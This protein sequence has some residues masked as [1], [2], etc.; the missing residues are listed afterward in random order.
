[1]HLGI[2]RPNSQPSEAYKN[3][4]KHYPSE[5]S[6]FLL[7]N[8]SSQKLWEHR[9]F[10]HQHRNVGS[11]LYNSGIYAEGGYAGEIQPYEFDNDVLTQA[12]E[13]DEELYNPSTGY[14][15]SKVKVGTLVNPALGVEY[16]IYEEAMPPPNADYSHEYS[17][18]RN[19]NMRLIRARWV[20]P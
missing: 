16:D 2:E 4:A 18:M 1:M 11:R 17:T 14:E 3:A 19:S 10:D 5:M 12:N 7:G 9:K 8:G 13:Y 20:R 15:D 6:R